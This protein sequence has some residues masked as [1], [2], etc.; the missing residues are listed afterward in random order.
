MI[1]P[2]IFMPKVQ[3]GHTV[4]VVVV[5][6]FAARLGVIAPIIGH[7]VTL[8]G[9]HSYADPT[10]SCILPTIWLQVVMNASVLTACI[11]GMQRVLAELRSGIYTVNVDTDAVESGRY[12]SV[13]GT[14]SSRVR[15][16][17]SHNGEKKIWEMARMGSTRMKS[18]SEDHIVGTDTDRRHDLRTITITKEVEQVAEFE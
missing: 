10:W 14:N 4:H 1:L 17:I 11:P 6:C 8:P 3:T 7:I 16:D 9:Q 18:T 2:A 5:L 15:T 13:F 12:G